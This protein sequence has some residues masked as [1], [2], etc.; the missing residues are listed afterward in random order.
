MV[1]VV[2][3]SRQ[4]CHTATRSLGKTE[5]KNLKGS[6]ADDSAV[7]FFALLGRRTGRSRCRSFRS[8]ASFLT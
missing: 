2:E 6:G 1:Q 3:Y 5:G 8:S 7:V 4:Q